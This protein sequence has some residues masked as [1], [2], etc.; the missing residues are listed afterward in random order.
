MILS[1]FD[2]NHAYLFTATKSSD[3]TLTG[4]YWSGKTLHKTWTAILDENAAL[5]DPEELT[6]LKD[7]IKNIDVSFPDLNGNMVNPTDE[8][9]RNKV[10]ILQLFGTWCPN[11]LD[12]TRFLS[13]WY[14]RNK[15]RDVAI[16]G[17][18]YETS[19]DFDYARGRVKKMIDKLGVE[20]DFVIAGSKDTE[21]ASATL[22]MLNGVLAFPT[23]IFIGRDGLVRKIHSGFTGPGTGIYYKQ[24]VHDFNEYV[25]ELLNDD[26]ASVKK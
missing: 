2:G 26:I 8:K 3:S 9:Y 19:E 17:L 13:E 18:A 14:S 24:Y 21:K 6:V 11:C 15:H 20:Y 25:N 7:G 1:T 23:T 12:E 22:P 5:P 10:V 4:H 16:I